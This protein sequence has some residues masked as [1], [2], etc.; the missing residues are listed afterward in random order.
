M[1]FERL[2]F[3]AIYYLFEGS[4]FAWDLVGEDEDCYCDCEADLELWSFP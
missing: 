1:D 4:I 2:G 3:N